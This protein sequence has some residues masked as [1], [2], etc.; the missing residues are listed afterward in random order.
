M[1][2]V[3]VVVNGTETKVYNNKEKAEA[4]VKRVNY[5]KYMA[6]NNEGYAYVV[7]TEVVE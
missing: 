2:K 6:G 1:K 4:E 3:Y 5:Y 7:E